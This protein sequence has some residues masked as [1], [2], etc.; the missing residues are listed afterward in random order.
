MASSS[1]SSSTGTSHTPQ[2][3]VE[4]EGLIAR[5]GDREILSG[6]D[7]HVAM[8]EIRVILGGSG[9]GKSTLIKHIIGLH[10]PTAGTVKLLGEDLLT[11]DEPHQEALVARTGMVFQNGALL[12]SLT[13]RDNIALPILERSPLPDNLIDEIVHIK[14]GLVGLPDVADYM[15]RQ[16]SGGM[17]KRVALARAIACDPEILFCDE[18]SAGLDPVTAAGID[19][20]IL[21]LRD[22]FGMAIVIVTHELASI[23]TVADNVTMLG[24]GRVIA[25]A[26]LEEIE[27]I[28]PNDNLQVHAF[29][30]RSS[31][32]KSDDHASIFDMIYGAHHRKS[33]TP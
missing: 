25:D 28:G 19:R 27:Q 14:L 24:Q 18:P 13:V 22:R 31:K 21:D 8:G 23:H 10:K 7:L 6:V 26:S 12:N 30:T 20:L 17:A 33:P 1:P 11:A 9:S 3:A 29:F 32:P 4:V 15:P 2:L 16:L 5:Y